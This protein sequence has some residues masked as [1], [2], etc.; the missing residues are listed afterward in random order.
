M[1]SLIISHREDLK[2]GRVAVTART[3][4]GEWITVVMGHDK[5][6]TAIEL[7]MLGEAARQ[8]DNRATALAARAGKTDWSDQ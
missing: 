3:P 4:G 1:T 8:A 2:D 7:A 5:I 6:G